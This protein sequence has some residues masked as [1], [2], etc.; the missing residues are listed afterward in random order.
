MAV[1][2]PDNIWTP[3][4]GDD[5]ALT[6]DL[7]AMAD[8]VQDALNT[9]KTYRVGTNAERIALTGADL[10]EGLSFYAT[11]T[12]ALWRYNGTAWEPRTYAEAR[13]RAACPAS[14]VLNVTFPAGRFSVV[15]NVQATPVNNGTVGF[16]HITG[17]TATGME[18]RFFSFG[19]V[20][21]AGNVDWYASQ[22]TPTAAAG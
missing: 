17:L 18:V 9:V 8:T 11:D 4:A 22:A 3:D 13:G 6:V 2:S 10:F 12:N 20:Q 1:T 14:G 5:Y 19:G 15:P 21:I 16:A 7:A